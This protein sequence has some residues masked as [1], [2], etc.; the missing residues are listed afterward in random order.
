MVLPFL[1]LFLLN[2]DITQGVQ[3]VATPGLPGVVHTIDDRAT[4]FLVGEGKPIAAAGYAGRGRVVAFGHDGYLGEGPLATG[5]TKRLVQNAIRWA[6]GKP[7]PLV[8]YVRVS[9]AAQKALGFNA[10]DVEQ[11]GWK[12][13]VVVG[14]F[15]GPDPK[16]V[17]EVLS[18]GG[19]AVAAVTPWG[20]S[21]VNPGKVL[22][23]DQNWS[24]ILLDAGLAFGDG[25]ASQ[26]RPVKDAQEARSL[27]AAEAM[28]KPDAGA[29]LL[30]EVIR[31]LPP[32]HA[33]VGRIRRL[34][35]GRKNVVPTEATPVEKKNGLDR[36]ALVVRMLDGKTDADPASVDFP[37]SVARTAPRVAREVLVRTDRAHW[38]G[39]G[40]YA[41]P[42]EEISLAA[43]A[44]L[45]GKGLRLQI[46]VHSDQLWHLDKWQRHPQIV[47]SAPVDRPVVR[48][49]SPFGGL[50]VVDV[51]RRIGKN[52]EVRIA[53]AVPAPRYVH[54]QT[55][56][57][58]W[59]LEREHP[60]P[61]AEFESESVVITVPTVDAL[62]VG[63]PKALMDLW[64]RTLALFA[65]LDGYD[66]GRPER[67]VADRQI[68]A[69]YMHSGYPIMTWMD[70]TGLVTSVDQLTGIGSWGHWH[71]IGH[72]R[73]KAAWTW[74]GTGEVTCNFYSL[75]AM[76]RIA[77]KGI[78]DRLGKEKQAKLEAHL[79]AGAPY[80]K[81]KG[82][83][84]LA[85][86][87]YAQLIDAFG[88]DALSAV[89]KGYGDQEG[90]DWPD[91]KKRDEWMV[92]Y[93]RQVNR[94]LGPFFQAW[95]VPT[96]AEARD[97]IRGLETW[98]PA[99]WP[100]S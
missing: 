20:W 13:D 28:K 79:E 29:P 24:P 16:K 31:A 48:L 75:L 1:A 80:D 15:D 86:T 40:L 68:S 26:I 55:T 100:K 52:G 60:A 45:V 22:W 63:D 96:S 34:V 6:A 67:I 7:N 93:S 5:D 27:S 36:L 42:G 2:P 49:R 18:R 74:D 95:G 33:L 70:V 65:D 51:P 59:K 56:P 50:I 71:E 88:W 61:W 54:G 92:R 81:W 53:N 39:T 87:L 94:N 25:M 69:G 85:L 91:L 78:W 98:M 84:F 58:Q 76:E 11:S 83:P 3:T 47:V 17:R 77:G 37:G 97:S 19:G 82:D 90:Q 99:D 66:P 72:N 32:S 57:E 23:R 89:I 9:P 41:A 46:G 73:Q 8:G 14:A 30:A 43:P 12:V 21:M 62:K 44:E 10:V 35:A 4:P 38:Q 64:D